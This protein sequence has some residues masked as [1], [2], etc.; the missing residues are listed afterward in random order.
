MEKNDAECRSV[1]Y[2]DSDFRGVGRTD[3]TIS[4]C[5]K[6][7]IY[8]EITGLVA[9]VYLRTA[10]CIRLRNPKGDDRVSRPHP[11]GRTCFDGER[12]RETIQHTSIRGVDRKIPAILIAATV[13]LTANCFLYRAQKFR[14]VACLNTSPSTTAHPHQNTEC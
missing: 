3:R 13:R 1:D 6:H 12:S 4:S 8:V 5:P 2:F 10:E 14:L 9:G 7:E 11:A